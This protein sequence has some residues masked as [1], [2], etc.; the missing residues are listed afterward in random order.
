MRFWLG[1]HQPHW[2]ADP[3]CAGVDLFVSRSTLKARKTMPAAVTDWALDSGGFSEIQLHGRWTITPEEYIAEVRRYLAIGRLQWA[4]PMDWMCEPQ[5][6]AGLVERRKSK[7]CPACLR[8]HRKTADGKPV[9]LRVASLDT[10]ERPLFVCECGYQATG[11][12]PRIHVARWRAWAAEAGTVMAASVAEADRLG[13]GAVVVFHGTGLSV[14]EHQRRTVENFLEL[15]RLAP[16]LPFIPVLQG[17]SLY[18]YWRCEEMYRAAGVDL[19][20]ET[21][22]GV[23]TVCRRQGTN[24]ATLIMQSLAAGGLRLHGFGF[25]ILG[26]RASA[27]V[28]A[29]ADSLAWSDTARR[30]PPLPGHDKPGP[31]RR[32]GHINCANCI[33]YALM[34]RANL[35]ADL[36]K[37]HPKPKAKPT[38]KPPLRTTQ[39]NLFGAFA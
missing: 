36:G 4:A 18:D 19:K 15:R 22:V 23:G 12:A 5:V 38:R 11:K 10:E 24:E 37:H 21:L 6:I 1:T 33:E 27:D 25:K 8:A 39:L 9:P 30:A 29:S 14:E 20:A 34:W 17:W 3:R 28:L 7:A 2:L 26:L 13:L 16:D 35:M 32:T 31:G